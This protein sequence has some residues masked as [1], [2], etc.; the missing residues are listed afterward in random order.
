MLLVFAAGAV[1]SQAQARDSRHVVSL[2]DLSKDAAQ[3]SQNRA[4]DEASV[5]QLFSSGQAQKALKSAK[6][7]Y[8][9]VDGAISQLSDEDLAQVASRARQAQTDFAAGHISGQGW[10]IILV[11]I[12]VLIIVLAIVF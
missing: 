7:D 9:R 12:A 2:D 8:Q 4:A 6:I 5:R 3:P 11:C 10:I 1:R